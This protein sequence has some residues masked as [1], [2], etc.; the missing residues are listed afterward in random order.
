MQILASFLLSFALHLALVLGSVDPLIT[1]DGLSSGGYMATQYQVAFS[2]SVRGAAIFASGPYYCAEAILSNALGRCMNGLT[3]IPVSN[4]LSYASRQSGLGLIDPVSN[5]AGHSVFL[6]SGTLDATVKP[7]VVKS[8]EEMY[9]AWG[10]SNIKAVFDFSAAH[11]MPTLNYGNL[12][13]VSSAPFISKCNY[14]GAGEAL[15]H[16]YGGS[17]ADPGTAINSNIIQF[18]QSDF[19]PNGVSPA[20]ISMDT[21]GYAYIPSGCKPGSGG[22]CRLHVSFHGCKQYYDTIGMAYVEN[23]GYNRWAETNNII[24]LYP[25]TIA[26]SFLPSNPNGCWDW[27]GY[28]DASYAL[29][30]GPQMATVNN[31]VNYFINNY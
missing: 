10:V 11:T 21:V 31:I 26:S 6:F 27:W 19:T 23:A 22:S 9:K 5:I 30:R 4:L 29:K 16:L 3:T 1:V 14:D 7:V 15:Q 25:Q 8:L 20:S 18:D 17:L 24:V 28:V 12:C 13:T 2:S